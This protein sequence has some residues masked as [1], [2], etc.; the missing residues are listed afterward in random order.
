MRGLIYRFQ[1]PRQYVGSWHVL[2]QR[3]DVTNAIAVHAT[4]CNVLLVKNKHAKM[5]SVIKRSIE[6]FI[7]ICYECVG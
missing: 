2:W 6:K 4:N 5:S 3:S 7:H 1:P